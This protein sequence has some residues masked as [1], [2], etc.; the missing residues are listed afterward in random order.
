MA[1]KNWERNNNRK[2]KGQYFALPHA[3]MKSEK[4]I[5]LSAHAVKLLNDLGL[6]YNGKNNGDL[7]ATW[8]MMRRRGWKSA[9]TLYKAIKELLAYE[10][11]IVSRQGGRHSATLYAVTWNNIDECKGKLDISSTVAPLGN[12]MTEKTDLEEYK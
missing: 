3:V 1:S 8:S 2:L 4:Y 12:W 11:I 5:A 10:F 9:S 7:C 6:Q